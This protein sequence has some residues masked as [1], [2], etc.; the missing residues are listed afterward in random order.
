MEVQHSDY[1]PI[2]TIFNLLCILRTGRAASLRALRRAMKLRGLRSLEKAPGGAAPGGPAN[3]AFWIRLCRAGGLLD[4]SVMPRPT[5]LAPDWLRWPLQDQLG[6]LLNAWQQA[7]RA[8]AQK[9]W[10]EAAIDRLRSGAALSSRRQRDLAGLQLL[11]VLTADHLTPLGA[12]LLHPLGGPAWDELPSTAAWQLKEGSLWVPFPPDWVLLW[13][14]EKY[15]RPAAP[16]LYP[17]PKF[18]A[19]LCEMAGSSDLA[20]I[21][22]AGFD[23]APPDGVLSRLAGQPDLRFISNPVLEFSHAADLLRLRRSRRLRRFL[24][25]VLSARHVVLHRGDVPE[26]IQSL[27]RSGRYLDVRLGMAPWIAGVQDQ[28]PGKDETGALPADLPLLTAAERAGLLSLV[29]LGEKLPGVIPPPPGLTAK[30]ETG[31]VPALRRSAADQAERAFQKILPKPA[32]IPE[33]EI[34]TQPEQEVIKTIQKAI[35]LSESL[36]VLY[37][38][39]A[40]AAAQPRHLT[41]LLLETR[42]PHTYLLAY[43]HMRRANRTF[44][45]DRLKLTGLVLESNQDEAKEKILPDAELEK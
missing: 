42:G 17:L 16:G 6:H 39:A 45:L 12:A 35:D 33:P 43:C 7:P 27:L 44:R 38:T 2:E 11:G 9:R 34:S 8:T 31:L 5:L 14:L 22:E 23:G 3:L 18:T 4:E 1:F 40:E 15:L 24:E 30:L 26:F 19:D 28:V 41:P 13:E 25:Q 36:D 29:L 10:R 32:H 21:L 20:I 37:Q